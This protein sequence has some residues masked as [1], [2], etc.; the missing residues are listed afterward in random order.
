[1]VKT[2]KNTIVTNNT[3][4]GKTLKNFS[5]KEQP[6]ITK[7]K[8]MLENNPIEMQYMHTMISSIPHLN[9][10][11]NTPKTLEELFKKLNHVLTEAPEF[12]KTLVVGTPLSAIL[13]MTMGS[14]EGFAA[15][16]RDKINNMFREVLFEYKK[17][18]DSPASR[19]VLNKSTSGWFG[20]EASKKI[21]MSEYQCDPSKPYYG[22]TSWNDFFTR[23]LKPGVR[24][25]VEP[26]NNNVV[27]SACD[28]TIY[29]IHFNVKPN[30]KFWIKTQPYSLN[31]M[32]NGDQY[33]VD[34]FTGGTIYQA[35]LNPFNY[36]R[37]HSP[38]S[39]TIEKA[40]VKSGLYFT[41]V[42]AFGED[43]SDQDKSMEYITNV[44]TRAFIFIKA[45][46]PKIGTVCIMPVGMVEISSC[47]INKNIKPGY[48]VKKGEEIGFF[49]YGG[50]THCIF[51][52][53][54]VIKKFTHK[55]HD[56]VKMGQIIAEIKE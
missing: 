37:W 3:K 30:T 51:F 21:N 23:K 1:M 19:S 31:A 34:K 43:P 9:R 27:N 36:H 6:V 5:K 8:K 54:N 35:F 56:F 4:N 11:K 25:I 50:S 45:D 42:N 20:K 39:G 22:F 41:Q 48:K 16:R 32:L 55:K 26:D 46:N 2:K 53:P 28:S 12:N 52:E 18:L 38:I 47:I 7:F 17:F 44:N 33:Y 40:Y 29:R 14:P 10:L 49:A 24:P 13:L 15:Y